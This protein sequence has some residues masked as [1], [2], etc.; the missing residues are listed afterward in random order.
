[1]NEKTLQL[2]AVG[3]GGQVDPDPLVERHFRF[4]LRG[5]RWTRVGGKNQNGTWEFAEKRP[6][7][8]LPIHQ[9]MV[10]NGVTI[11]FQGHDHLFAR[12]ELDGVIYQETP[13]PADN[14]YLAFNRVS[15]D[16]DERRAFSD[17]S[18]DEVDQNDGVVNEMPGSLFPSSSPIGRRRLLQRLW[19][20]SLTSHIIAGRTMENRR[21]R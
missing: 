12:Q 20:S 13:N 10:K 16:L 4:N 18:V 11:F 8:R 2:L 1:V 14:T 21:I 9:L 15:Q 19:P 5:N 3:L 6:G 17:S 7:W